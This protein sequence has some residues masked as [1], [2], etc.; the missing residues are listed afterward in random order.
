[1][2]PPHLNKLTDSSPLAT[3]AKLVL[4]ALLLPACT[5]FT[6]FDPALHTENYLETCSDS[7]DNDL[8]GFVD[9][10][11]TGCSE[12]DH[13]K[14]SSDATCVDGK[15]NDQD[16]LTDCKDPSCCPYAKCFQDATCGEKTRQ[17]CTD[18]ADN[19]NNGLTD[20][21]D[22]SCRG[23]AECCTRPIPV[24]A[25]SFDTVSGGCTPDDCSLTS[26]KCC[27]KKEE[28][29]NVFDTKRWYAWGSPLPRIT[30][31]KLTPNQPC[32]CPSSGLISVMD[33]RLQPG[34]QLEFDAALQDDDTAYLAVGLVENTSI[35]SSSL[36]CGGINNRFKLLLGMEIEASTGDKV[37]VVRVII[38]ESIRMEKKGVALTGPQHF[39]VAV[40]SDGK[41][42]FFH[43]GVSLHR[44]TI[45]VTAAA[46]RVRLL[47]Q[48][49]SGKATLDNILLA[50]R[51]GCISPG[52]WTTGPTG[53]AAVVEPSGDKDDF[54]SGSMKAPS[55]IHDGTLYRL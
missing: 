44:S 33:T 18:G 41:A 27:K 42:E 45:T 48:G 40:D 55:V 29:C 7:V 47:L 51:A 35:S 4:L 36:T 31:K 53:A 6:E 14:E 10:K 39:R 9:C 22:F 1:M 46:K 25:E 20:C 30:G 19:N 17:A 24:L 37:A 23:I 16:G 8:D 11:D 13:C 21:S 26:D 3:T 15:D 12:Q 52:N 32:S 54:D 2:R 49:R 38:S 28:A 34:L 50:K 43:N 5:I